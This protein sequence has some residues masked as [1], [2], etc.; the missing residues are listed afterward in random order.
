[1]S[2]I[3]HQLNAGVAV[4]LTLAAVAPARDRRAR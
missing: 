1:M 3:N 4:S 2:R